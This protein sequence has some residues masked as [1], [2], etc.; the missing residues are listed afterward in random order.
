MCSYS[1]CSGPAPA[2]G[3][4]LGRSGRC[5]S[6]LRQSPAAP[7]GNPIPGQPQAVVSIGVDGSFLEVGQ[8]FHP[9][10][11]Q[12]LPAKIFSC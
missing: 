6:G 8:P 5:Q 9:A 12:A 2:S 7:A 1:R 11:I 10:K 4:P 3:R